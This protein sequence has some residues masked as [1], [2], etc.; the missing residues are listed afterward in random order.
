M[1]QTVD[2]P[3]THPRAIMMC[4]GGFEDLGENLGETIRT[5]LSSRDNTVIVRVNKD[6]LEKLDVLVEGGVV[7][8]RSE[9]A[10]FLIAEGIRARHT[11]FDQISEKVEQIRGVK[12]ELRD[13]LEKS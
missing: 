8:S 9:A 3:I 10:A 12:Q 4:C 2:S 13:L 11:L 6:S 1:T 5:L 7:N